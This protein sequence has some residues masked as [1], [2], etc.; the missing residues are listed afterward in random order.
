MGVKR[1]K[2]G[3]K[4]MKNRCKSSFSFKHPIDERRQLMMERYIHVNENRDCEK[5]KNN[6]HGKLDY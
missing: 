4:L 6:L 5:S 3:T 1:C 2:I